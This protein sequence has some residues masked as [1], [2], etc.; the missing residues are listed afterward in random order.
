MAHKDVGAIPDLDSATLENMQ[1]TLTMDDLKCH[2]M[3]KNSEEFYKKHLA[4]I[5][6]K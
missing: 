6:G 4:D 1:A 2:K 5:T 3:L